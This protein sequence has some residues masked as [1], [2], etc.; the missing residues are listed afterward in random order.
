LFREICLEVAREF[1]DLDVNEQLVDS[2]AYWLVRDP[3]RFDVLLTMNL[4]GDILSDVAAGV[5]DG[6]GFVPS[7]SVG[8]RIP[9]AEPVHGAAPDIAGQGIA[10]PYGLLFSACLLMQSVGLEREATMLER[11]LDDAISNGTL[12]SDVG[13]QDNS[14]DVFHAVAERCAR[15]S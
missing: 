1:P 4:Y 7:L 6:L 8:P 11:A 2:A 3:G 9:L 13:G 5:A 14:A 10:N 12:T 15:N